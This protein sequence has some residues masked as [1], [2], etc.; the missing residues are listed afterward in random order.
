MV[1]AQAE[2][3]ASFEFLMSHQKLAGLNLIQE[4][5]SPCFQLLSRPV[6]QAGSAPYR[7]VYSN[8]EISDEVLARL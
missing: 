4:C 1:P 2:S 6:N 7:N 5:V 3:A 8:V